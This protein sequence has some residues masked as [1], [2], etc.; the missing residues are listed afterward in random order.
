MKKYNQNNFTRYKQDVKASQPKDKAWQDYTRDELIT[1]FL[2]CLLVKLA[3]ALPS[4]L[5]TVIAAV[6]AATP[7]IEFTLISD[8]IN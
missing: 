1:K 6:D 4:V 3:V 2:P 8:I 7:F 5:L